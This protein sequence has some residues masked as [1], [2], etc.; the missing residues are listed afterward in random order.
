MKFL[1]TSQKGKIAPDA[2]GFK[3]ICFFKKKAQIS[4]CQ[5][6]SKGSAACLLLD[7]IGVLRLLPKICF[8]K[9]ETVDIN[10]S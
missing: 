9:S 10:Y 7:W 4:T 2:K 5:A 3:D 6:V 1:F 8:A